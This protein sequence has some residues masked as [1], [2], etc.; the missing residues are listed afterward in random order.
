VPFFFPVE[1]LR[2]KGVP[3][4]PPRYPIGRFPSLEASFVGVSES[5]AILKY[6]LSDIGPF[7]E[8][9]GTFIAHSHEAC[10]ASTV[11][12]FI[13]FL[14]VL[15]AQQSKAK[16]TTPPN[17]SLISPCYVWRRTSAP[18][19][20]MAVAARCCVSRRRRALWPMSCSA[21]V[22]TSS[23][24]LSSCDRSVRGHHCRA[25][26]FQSHSGQVRTQTSFLTYV[27]ARIRRVPVPSVPGSCRHPSVDPR[28]A[29]SVA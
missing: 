15:S 14:L 22:P 20:P 3:F 13:T 29:G 1:A 28:T 23:S 11:T 4:P 2:Q 27:R 19:S 21:I 12:Y 6:A 25:M 16:T 17:T 9:K 24:T 26:H 8:R 18:R 5:I 7:N 10:S